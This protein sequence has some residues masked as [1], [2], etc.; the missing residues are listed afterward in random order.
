MSYQAGGEFYPSPQSP[1]KASAPPPYSAPS[2]GL[3]APPALG[4]A[5]GEG[6]GADTELLL[7]SAST[8]P[9]GFPTDA[10]A[11]AAGSNF[12]IYLC[13]AWSTPWFMIGRT[14][15]RLG[16]PRA[17]YLAAAAFLCMLS[18]CKASPRLFSSGY[19]VLGR[20]VRAVSIEVATAL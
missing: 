13:C 12:Y 15:H 9:P 4:S 5:L 1:A 14:A 8:P 2:P 18:C 20:V 3:Y 6:R 19:F 11:F 16:L 10:S 17:W 7:P